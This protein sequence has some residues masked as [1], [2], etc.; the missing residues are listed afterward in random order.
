MRASGV[1]F[2]AA[3]GLG[4]HG[5]A[6]GWSGGREAQ[7]PPGY[8]S[9]AQPHPRIRTLGRRFQERTTRAQ[10]GPSSASGAPTLA[11]CSVHLGAS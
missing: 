6:G 10:V 2:E 7:P 11:D 1:E 5:R 9:G 8:R 4:L 3:R